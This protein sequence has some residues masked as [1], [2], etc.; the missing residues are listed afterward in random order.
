[1]ENDTQELIEVV[2]SWHEKL[3]SQLKLITES[4]EE[5][6][7]KFLTSSGE[8]AELAGREKE[9]FKAGVEVAL[10]MF[11]KLPFTVSYMTTEARTKLIDQLERSYAAMPKWAKRVTI[12]AIGAPTI[13]PE[14][15]KPFT[16][17]RQVLNTASDETLEILR[18]DFEDNGDLLPEEV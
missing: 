15:G 4:D 1:M 16:S 9:L 18:G 3:V 7:F 10:D 11:K 2:Q 14:T 12:H 13:N 6:K 17:F 8:V 5:S